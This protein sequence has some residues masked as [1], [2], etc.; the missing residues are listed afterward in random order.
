MI[1]LEGP[2]TGRH[3]VQREH[4]IY[5]LNTQDQ[6]VEMNLKEV[7]QRLGSYRSEHGSKILTSLVEDKVLDFA[8]NDESLIVATENGIV[9]VKTMQSK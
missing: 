2:A 5:Y 1:W 3:M 8:I 6:V 7:F 4:L 9:K